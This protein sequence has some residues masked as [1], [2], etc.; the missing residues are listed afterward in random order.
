MPTPLDR[1]R[2]RPGLAAARDEADPFAIILFDQLRVSRQLVRVTAREFTWLQWL[3]GSN[4]LRD[5]QA[6]AM[7][8]GGG[9]LVPLEPLAALVER[10]DAALF[11]DG[12]RFAERLTGPVREPVCVGCYPA[13]PDELRMQLD[14][15]FTAPGGPGVPDD[16]GRCREPSGTRVRLGSPDLPKSNA[17]LR[18]LLAPHIDYARGGVSYAWAYKEL[19][20]RCDARL[21]VIVGTSHYSPARFT[22]SRQDFRTP[23]GLVQTDQTYVDRLVEYYGDGLFDDPLAH[24]PEHSIELEVVFLQHLLGRHRPIKIVPLLVG[25]FADCIDS[26]TDPAALSDVARMVEALR[27]AEAECPEPVC[28]VISGDLAHIGPKFGDSGRLQAP[29]LA[30]SRARDE[31]ILK[32]AAAADP[33][34]YFQVIAAEGDRRRICGLPP[35]WITLQVTKPSRGRV[36]HY[37]QYVH[38]RGSESVSFAA[39]AFYA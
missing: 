8:G 26:G 11:L 30:E 21:F 33:A 13:D 36:L 38:S 1:P 20:E 35:T 29:F 6:A 9:L 32:R 3:D 37:D 16:S 39:A 12:P 17:H 22:L 23:L 18:A 28:Y 10:L 7:C 4:T 5:V 15:Y 14:A 34:A 31:A 25:S 24:V 27:K 19:A 2:L